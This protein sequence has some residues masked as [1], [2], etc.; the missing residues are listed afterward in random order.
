MQVK[1]FKKNMNVT[2]FNPK[3]VKTLHKKLN[4]C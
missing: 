1:D 4:I 2:I 3:Q